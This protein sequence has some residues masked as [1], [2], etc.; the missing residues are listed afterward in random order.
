MAF[1]LLSEI[2]QYCT[3]SSKMHPMRILAIDTSSPTGGTAA[4]EDKRLLGHV[5][6]SDRDDYSVRFFRE[7]SVLLHE[8]GLRVGDFDIY[9]VTAGPGSFTGLRVGLTVVKA[10]AEVHKKQIAAV[11]GLQAVAAQAD[12]ASEYVAAV[13]DG[14]RGQVFGGL[15]RKAGE[16]LELV[17]EEGVM[18]PAEFVV[19]VS[20]RMGAS[21][22]ENRVVV[23]SP[24]PELF[25]E[26]LLGSALRDAPLQKVS[27]DL[28][29][30]I[31]RLAYQQALEG[32]LV[33]AL[34][35]DANYVRRSD[36]ESYWKDTGATPAKSEAT[37]R[38]L[39]SADAAAISELEKLCPEA[40][41]WGESGYL[42][43]GSN[44][45]QGWAAV[46]GGSP[47]GF[48]VVRVAADE[49]EILNLMVNPNA[50]RRKIATR[51]LAGAYSHAAEH[52][53]RRIFLE[54]RESNAAAR[55]V[56]GLHGFTEQGRRKRYYSD[57]V[58]DALAM[59]KDFRSDSHK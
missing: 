5:F 11:S 18:N 26:A 48:L 25:R 54:V 49:M 28:A 32:E 12:D 59:S 1:E 3:F 33:D 19:E 21:H 43:V 56:Y 27:S 37:I 47:V 23:V 13:L 20:Q 39:T 58:E 45:V 8:I 40:P 6:T 2:V 53:V 17:G 52:N 36:A 57:P 4:F 34:S 50:R 51:L 38:P 29:P 9:G 31:G 10:W 30:W 44:G 22:P 46:S 7:L 35:L 24:E 15:Y 55:A 14:R 16:R 42:Q 41:R